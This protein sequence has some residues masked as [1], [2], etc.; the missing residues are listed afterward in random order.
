MVRGI[1]SGLPPDGC[2]HADDFFSSS[3]R[4]D[5]LV[6][7]REDLENVVLG[8]GLGKKSSNEPELG[9]AGSTRWS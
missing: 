3:R 4:R 6:K 2:T 5:G 8:A 9:H 1:H 7:S